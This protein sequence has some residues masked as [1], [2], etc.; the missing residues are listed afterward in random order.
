MKTAKKSIFLILCAIVLSATN[1]TLGEIIPTA[2]VSTSNHKYFIVQT[3]GVELAWSIDNAYIIWNKFDN[4]LSADTG[5]ICFL[6][7][8]SFQ[9]DK[10]LICLDSYSGKVLWKKESGMHRALEVTPDGVFVVYSSSAAAK[11]F[12]RITGNIEWEK[13][14]SG[15]GCYYFYIIDNMLQI[16]TNPTNM[17]IL[18]LNG[19]LIKELDSGTTTYI[20]TRNETFVRLN[21]LISTKTDTGEI[22]WEFRDM[23]NVFDFMPVFID[24]KIFI[25]TGIKLG[26]VYALD[27]ES[28][29]LLW[30]TNDIVSNVIYS[31]RKSSIYVMRNDGRLVALDEKTG[32][33]ETIVTFSF[34]LSVLDEE[35]DLGS[36]QIAY[37][38]SAH[39]LFVSVGNSGQLFAFKEK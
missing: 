23:D 30:K 5:Q 18:D 37:D 4:T 12:D 13:Q 31:P 25:R 11:K 17:S 6:G 29:N 10:H 26:S 3:Q 36:Y 21:G 38:E 2:N 35:R 20:Y 8:Q 24:S 32:K 27:R 28:G 34:P 16:S 15:S 22:R 9:E 7:G 1:C 33:E 39:L 14:L 19:N